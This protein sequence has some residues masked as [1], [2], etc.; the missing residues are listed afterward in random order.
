MSI[1]P[2]S[3]NQVTELMQ[4]VNVGTNVNFDLSD[5]TFANILGGKID[6]LNA[7]QEMFTQ[8][9]GPIG[10]PVGLSIEGLTDDPFKVSAIGSA[11]SAEIGLNQSEINGNDEN[12]LK[13]GGHKIEDFISQL[14][15]GKSSV[16]IDDIMQIR[17]S[18]STLKAMQNKDNFSNGL[19][20][21][22]KKQAAN[23]YGVMGK[24]AASSVS[25]L[26]SSM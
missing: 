5:D 21:F 3:L 14:G 2:N 20:N 10:V 9:M 8:L 17:E 1:V 26:L 19:G 12:V 15:K 11:D 6:E 13:S 25:D 4:G 24:T 18:K 7:P 23:L 22:M 16:S